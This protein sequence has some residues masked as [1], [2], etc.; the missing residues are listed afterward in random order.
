MKG[1]L[2]TFQNI[3]NQGERDVKTLVKLISLHVATIY[4]N[5]NKINYGVSLEQKKGAGP[6]N[7]LNS[8]DKIRL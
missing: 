3:Y 7:K 1:S 8:N 6:T 4:S 2:V 5:W